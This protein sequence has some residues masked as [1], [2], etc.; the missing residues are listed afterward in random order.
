MKKN[1]RVALNFATFN[2]DQLN[3]FLILLLVCLKNNPLFP[4]LPVTYAD[5]QAL[6]ADYQAKLAAAKVG[7]QVDTA[8]FTEAR[9]AVIAALRQ[10][11]GY[12]QSLGLTNESD[13]LS[14]GFDIV[15]PGKNPQS[16]LDQPLFKLDNSV[17][18]QL[19]INLQAVTNAKAYHVQYCI[20]TG[21]WV[22]L[23]I[24]PNTRD[25][26]IPNTVAGT[27]YSAR[28][29]AVGGSTQYSPWSM[30]VTLMST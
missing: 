15:I 28:I 1:I 5:L 30:T 19:G 18:G 11:A 7:G 25:I 6:V 8:A 26:V 29:Q 23:G 21:A 3:S 24:F 12:I 22:D 17:P 4:N 13:I 27:T 9:D 16:P 20:G 10:I 2:N 14:S